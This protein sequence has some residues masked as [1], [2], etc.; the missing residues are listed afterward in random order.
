MDDLT[1]SRTPDWHFGRL[2]DQFRRYSAHQHDLVRTLSDQRQGSARSSDGGTSVS[3]GCGGET[4]AASGARGG[5]F[6]ELFEAI[7]MTR[8]TD[9]IQPELLPA[10][11]RFMVRVAPVGRP[12]RQTKRN[13]DYFAD[14]NAALAA[15]GEKPMTVDIPP[16]PSSDQS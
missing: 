8:P 14:L 15:C 16:A 7:G 4:L 6:A 10:R 5:P 1:P 2:S 12:H 9:P 13:Y 3:L 11:A